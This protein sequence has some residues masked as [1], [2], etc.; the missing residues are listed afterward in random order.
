MVGWAGPEVRNAATPQNELNGGSEPRSDLSHKRSFQNVGR[1]NIPSCSRNL[2][3]VIRT[4]I[5]TE[6]LDHV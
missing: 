3:F 4:I 1:A 5:P 2:A 6:R